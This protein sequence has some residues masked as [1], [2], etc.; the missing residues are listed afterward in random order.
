M[1]PILN[2]NKQQLSKIAIQQLKENPKVKAELAKVKKATQDVEAIFLK[3]LIGEMRKS[4]QSGMF[5]KGIEGE[6]YADFLDEA[7]AK[8]MSSGNGVGMAK[9]L[10]GRMEEAT[11]RKMAATLKTEQ[12]MDGSKSIPKSFGKEINP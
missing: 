1:N 5:G 12:S 6:M 2:L 7:V 9:Q 8:A 3:Q 10:Y 11:L 4:S